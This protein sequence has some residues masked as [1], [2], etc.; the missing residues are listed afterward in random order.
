MKSQNEEPHHGNVSSVSEGVQM[1]E[2]DGKQ[3]LVD[4]LLAQPFYSLDYAAKI[5]IKAAGRP[6]PEVNLI[7][8]RGGEQ[9]KIRTVWYDKYSWLTGSSTTNRVYNWPCLLMGT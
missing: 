6:T 2:W 8:V 9:K 7:P 3:N 4:Y 5:R 1:T